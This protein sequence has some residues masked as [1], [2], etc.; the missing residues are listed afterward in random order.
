MN[1]LQ[2]PL[3]SIVTP[4]YNQGEFLEYAILSVLGQDYPNVEY[5]IVDGDSKDGSLEI[6]KRY[7]SRVSWWVSEP[8]R[9]QAEAI[10]KGL[11]RA[12]GEI[13]AWLNS[14]DLYLPGAISGAVLAFQAHPTAGMVYADAITID[15]KGCPIKWLQFPD[16]GL[17]HL[18]GFRIICQP[19]VFIRRAVL[20]QVG[21][22]DERY[23]YMLD[24]QLWIRLAR[25]APVVHVPTVWAAS[26]YHLRAKNVSQAEGFAH[27]TLRILAW[28]QTQPDL[29][30]IFRRH[31]RQIMAG[32]YRL[33]GRYLLEAGRATQAL[34]SYVR[35]LFY[36]P[37]YVL[38]HWHRIGYALLSSMKVEGLAMSIARMRRTSRPDLSAIPGLAGWY[39]L[40]LK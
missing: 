22:L 25:K 15:E 24:H 4:S 35:A 2:P 11:Q 38:R 30:A 16:W 13:V 23:H 8:D 12:R 7:A 3:V 19:A 34:Q 14:D 9:G 31:R 1:N 39:G 32:A 21:L 28:M 29:L 17:E 36:S 20:E 27:E 6:I 10:N 18:I 26:R 33:H 40:C 37:A 5:L